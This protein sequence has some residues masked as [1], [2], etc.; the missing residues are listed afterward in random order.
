MVSN[1]SIMAMGFTAVAGI[2]I[3]IVM[4]LYLNKKKRADISPFFIGAAVML[5][6]V[7]ILEG[8][9]NFLVLNVIAPKSLLQNLWFLAIYGG[10]M[11]G[12]FE[13]TGR[14]LAMKT[15]L[16]KKL[17]RNQNALMYG[18]GHGG[19]E[20]YAILF[21][22]SANNVTM[23]LLIN[24]GRIQEVL[25]QVPPEASDQ[26]TTLV[27]TLTEAP[28]YFF[29]AGIIER[30]FAIIV[31]LGLSVLVWF[32]VKNREK[33]YLF[34]LAIILHAG[35]NA[36]MF[37]IL[38]YSE[39]ILLTEIIIG[40]SACAIAYLAWR[41]WRSETNQNKELTDVTRS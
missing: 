41:V 12:I 7:F 3:P 15:A 23:A 19:F 14:Y 1:L 37:L 30:V 29:L 31:H 35:T 38:R 24:N 13:E 16:K 22:A 33:F 6:F 10:L 36:V 27:Q 2:F 39:S 9:L 5:G 17:N 34:P 11:A 32:A 40:I 4:F 18:A 26:L 25:T 28:A 8:S 21:L 20:A